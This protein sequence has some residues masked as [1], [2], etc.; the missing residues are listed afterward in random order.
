MIYSSFSEIPD[1]G[2]SWN[3]HRVQLCLIITSLVGNGPVEGSLTSNFKDHPSRSREFIQTMLNSTTTMYVENDTNC[4]TFSH[5]HQTISRLTNNGKNRAFWPPSC[6]FDVL[7][8]CHVTASRW[9][10][11][12]SKCVSNFNS[13]INDEAIFVIGIIKKVTGEKCQGVVPVP[14]ASEGLRI[15]SVS[16]NIK[17]I[18]IIIIII[19][20]YLSTP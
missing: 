18:I 7:R 11:I 10:D 3:R 19:T 9:C 14:K 15:K 5:P 13:N 1:F 6:T 4:T 20:C 16:S 8:M 17:I 12:W 2:N